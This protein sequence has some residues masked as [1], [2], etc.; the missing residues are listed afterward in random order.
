[1]TLPG[2]PTTAVQPTAGGR[3]ALAVPSPVGVD[4][5]SIADGGELERYETEITIPADYQYAIPIKGKKLPN[6]DWDNTAAKIGIAA[7]GYDYVNR[8]LGASFFLPEWV[9]DEQGN[10]QRNPI[11]RKDYIYL[12]MG[13]VWYNPTGA[14]Q[15]ATEDVEVDFNLTWMDARVNSKSAK[16]VMDD[17]TGLPAFDTFG[18]PKVTLTPDEELKALKTLSQLRTFGPRYAQTVA[19]VRLLKMASGIRSLPATDDGQPHAIKIKV[20]GFRDKMTPQQR[21][22]KAGGD[23]SAVYGK[24][25]DV[26]P[27][28]SA[29]MDE[30]GV[31]V[32]PDVE[33]VDRDAVAAAQAEAEAEQSV[34]TTAGLTPEQE[35]ELDK[36]AGA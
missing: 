5:L 14:L 25:P 13:A 26:K 21:I 6:G 18:N 30:V 28:T 4:I 29:E 33:Q 8:I 20:V 27:L 1:M 23:L 12:R 34:Q 16:V 22:A 11:H 31:D 10:P 17:G 7:D 36:A 19:R 35:A 32:D 15:L 9:H 2:Q 3:R 24:K